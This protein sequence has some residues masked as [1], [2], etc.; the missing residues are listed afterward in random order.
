MT[1]IY[2]KINHDWQEKDQ[3]VINIFLTHLG[4]KNKC[5]SADNCKYMQYNSFWKLTIN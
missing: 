2:Y 4:I 5:N 3:Y 1:N